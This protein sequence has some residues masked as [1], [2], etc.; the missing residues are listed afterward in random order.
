MEILFNPVS[1]SNALVRIKEKQFCREEDLVQQD[2]LWHSLDHHGRFSNTDRH[3][4]VEMINAEIELAHEF[5]LHGDVLF[6]TLGTSWAYE[7][8]PS[9]AIVANCHKIPNH[10]F[11]KRL[12]EPEESVASL[13]QAISA[14]KELNPALRI[15]FTVSPVR[16]IKDGIVE[17]QL[18][19][20][21]LLLVVHQLRKQFSDIAYFPAYE[22][23][24]D[25]LRSYR[26]YESDLIHP[27]AM[28][29]QYIWEKFLE[30]WV[31]P[32]CERPMKAIKKIKEAQDHRP[33]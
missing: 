13:T 4:A 22:I 16:H 25:D 19:K 27:N 2:E 5:I 33:V 24:M 28:A 6:L 32:D 30:T 7:W 12:L 11:N 1:I 15:G 8:K 3:K 18:S 17:N 29:V 23:M 10:Q 9:G 20:S 31:D 26:Y 14:I 21:M